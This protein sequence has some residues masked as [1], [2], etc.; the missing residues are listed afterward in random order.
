[1]GERGKGSSRIYF[2]GETAKEVPG[3]EE[4]K[5]GNRTLSG[6]RRR[7]EVTKNRGGRS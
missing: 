5:E 6:G 1:M 4:K 7:R 3:G 2:R